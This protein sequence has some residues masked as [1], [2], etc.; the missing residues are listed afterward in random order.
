[1]CWNTALLVCV[2]KQKC[3]R[4]LVQFVYI[5]EREEAVRAPPD[6]LYTESLASQDKEVYWLCHALSQPGGI[7]DTL[8]LGKLTLKV[9]NIT[10]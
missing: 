3:F 7:P 1:M 8:M 2:K 9:D 6:L 5:W 10:L 4:F